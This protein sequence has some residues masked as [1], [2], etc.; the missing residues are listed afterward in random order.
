GFDITNTRSEKTSVTVTKGWKDDNSK[1]RPDHITVHLLQNNKVIDTVK[2]TAAND[3][4]Y[5]F[6]DL[7]A[8]DNNGVA[9]E[10]SVKEEAIEGYESAV[11]GYDI[12]NLRVG[13]TSVKG[14]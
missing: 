11:E 4:T 13:K 1:D 14:T 2:V 8:Y 7:E 6:N 10:Y 9:Y 5:E 12:T 3:W